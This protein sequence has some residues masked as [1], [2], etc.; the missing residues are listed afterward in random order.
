MAHLEYYNTIVEIND[1]LYESHKNLLEKILLELG[2]YDKLEDF[3]TKFLDQPKLK[4]KKDPNEPSRAKSAFIL[5][6]NEKRDP[7]MQRCKQKNKIENK[8][9]NLGEVQKE[10]GKLWGD[11]TEEERKKFTALSEQDKIRYEN[12]IEK[13]KENLFGSIYSN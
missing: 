11:L 2:Q 4:A 9:F 1:R 3:V 6:C 12:E 10:L 7:I 8:K 5:F 13:Y